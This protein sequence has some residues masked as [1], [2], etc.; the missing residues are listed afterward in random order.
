MRGMVILTTS[1][2]DLVL[3]AA[4]EFLVRQ[5]DAVEQYFFCGNLYETA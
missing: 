5:D 4:T 1:Q 2:D 3:E